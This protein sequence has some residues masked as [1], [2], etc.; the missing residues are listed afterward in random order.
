[1]KKEKEIAKFRKEKLDHY[2]S[3]VITMNEQ[4]NERKKQIQRRKHL[5]DGIIKT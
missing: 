4:E 5:Y 1:M 2:Y 3:I